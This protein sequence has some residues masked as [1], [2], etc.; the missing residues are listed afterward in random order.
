LLA[1]NSRLKGSKTFSRLFRNGLSVHTENFTARFQPGDRLK[2]GIVTSKKVGK[3]HVRNKL[4]RRIFSIIQQHPDFAKL[5]DKKLQLAIICKPES[6][7][8]EFV[9]LKSE[10]SSILSRLA[11]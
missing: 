3:A 10:I 7:K 8:L 11:G 5:A 9:V 2:I 6:S 4:R 1:K